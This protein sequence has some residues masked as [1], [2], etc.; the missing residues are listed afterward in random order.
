MFVCM[1]IF[2]GLIG[3]IKGLRGDVRGLGWTTFTDTAPVF[4]PWGGGVAEQE[5]TRAAIER[6]ATACSK[7]KPEYGG[8]TG[9]VRRLVET[10]PNCLMSWPKFL[11]RLAAIYDAHGTAFV[12]PS[13]ADDMRTVTGLWPMRCEG[14]E[15]VEYEGEPWVVF[16]L[17]SGGNGALMLSEVAILTKFQL[18]S[19]LFGEPNCLGPT[20]RLIHAQN[21][22]QDAAV[23]NG[24]RIRFIAS[25]SGQV[26]PEDLKAKREQFLEDNFGPDNNGGVIVHDSTL[27]EVRQIEPQ[28]YVISDEEMARIQGNVC[29]Y[30]GISEAVLKNDYSEEQWGAWYEGRVE[31]FAVELGEALTAMLFSAVQV[32]HGNRVSFSSNRLEYASNA[33]KRNMVRDMLD[34]GVLSLNEAREV[35]QLPPVEGGD[36]RVIRGEYVDADTVSHL[37]ANAAVAKNAGRMPRQIHEKDFDLEGDDDIYND[38][39]S[40]GKGDFDE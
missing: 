40:Y 9:N 5:L 16:N 32:R 10:A 1:G 8:D 39:D 33:S 30:F 2:N 12:I 37:I 23:R 7:L 35:L 19:D 17:R 36:I 11:K 24:A 25:V 38:S 28:S 6:F 22:A 18:E 21:E 3:K 31:P 15:V 29:N 4:T 34:R 27:A 26:R 20:M 13:Y 14:A